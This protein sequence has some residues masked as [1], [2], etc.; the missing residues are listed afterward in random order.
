M[1]GSSFFFFA[2]AKGGETRRDEGLTSI[3]FS[4]C[5]AFLPPPSLTSSDGHLRL[6]TVSHLGNL[7]LWIVSATMELKEERKWS[8]SAVKKCSVMKVARISES[9]EVKKG[10]WR[11]VVGGLGEG[12]KGE[13]EGWDL[14][15]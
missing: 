4:F 2:K 12:A 1:F 14:V 15:W 3:L 5:S 9:S 10:D 8:T 7:T 13:V 6:L 11:I